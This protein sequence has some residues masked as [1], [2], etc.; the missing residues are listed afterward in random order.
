[1]ARR[2]NDAERFFFQHGGYSYDPKVETRAQ[3]RRS[4]AVAHADAEAWAKRAGITFVW[5]W[6]EEPY[7][8]GDAETKAPSEVLGCVVRYS[9]GTIG[10]SL[11]GIGDPDENYRRVVEAEL[12]LEARRDI[13]KSA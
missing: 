12:A 10:P 11:W 5:E 4:S 7:Q 3:G 9:T 8:M 2:M 1:M 13:C 6:D